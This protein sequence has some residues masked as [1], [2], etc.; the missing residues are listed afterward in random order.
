M[1]VLQDIRSAVQQALDEGQT[2]KW[3][4]DQLVAVLKRKG[5]WGGKDGSLRRL[6]TIYATNLQTALMAG[7]HRQAME[8]IDRAPWAQYMAI[9]D[10]RS[11]PAHAAM[12]GQIFRLDSPA[13]AVVSPPCGY[14]CRCSARYLSDRELEKRGLKPAEDIQ[15]LERDPPGKVPV[16]PLTGDSPERWIQR[17]VSVP[18]HLNPG[19]RLTLWAD[20]G[21]D[22]L[23][24]SDGA[25]RALVDKLL[26]KA[27]TL[28][29][30]IKMAVQAAYRRH[31]VKVAMPE[32]KTAAK[33]A[34]AAPTWTML[35]AEQ[36]S[37]D[38]IKRL[39]GERLDELLALV[40][41]DNRL[42]SAVLSDS[43]KPGDVPMDALAWWRSAMLKRLAEVRP[44]GGKL[45][46]SNKTGKGKA[47]TERVAAKLPADWIDKIDA[48]K[49]YSVQYSSTARGNHNGG[50]RKIVTDDGSTAEH[51]WIH[52]VQTGDLY[53]D[54]LF[55]R[56]HGRRTNGDALEWLGSN[57]GRN[58]M[59]RRDKYVDVYFGK[60]YGDRGAKEMMTMSYQALLG[61]DGRANRW[62]ALLLKNDPEMLRLALGALFHF[63]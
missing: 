29:D 9:R 46:I 10:H 24:G 54:G 44:V 19:E 26:A 56:E 23:P 36:A 52:A 25:E 39:G 58:E 47:V 15:I 8:Q 60:E 53:L 1:D 5:W 20:P 50:T 62:L 51:E 35:E 49:P 43:L 38:E 63:K 17:G 12:H 40:A 13:W 7:R 22:H 37:L 18:D 11:R 32:I 4:S 6:H 3:F 2:E 57:Y 21:W 55:Q 61:E 28:G 45:P 41:P 30:G 14:S 59:G 34:T 42:M 48:S 27:E 33:G 16:N 31:G